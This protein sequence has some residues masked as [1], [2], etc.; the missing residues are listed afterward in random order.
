MMKNSIPAAVSL[1]DSF[2]DS[3]LVSFSTA[4]TVI[5][6]SRPSFYRDIK[7]GRLTLVKVGNSS[8]LRVGELRALMGAE[9]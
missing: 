1:F 6:R 4:G 7:A 5:D 2:P 9:K 3:A 8:R